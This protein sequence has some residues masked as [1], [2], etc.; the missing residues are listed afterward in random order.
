MWDKDYIG[1]DQGAII[2]MIENYRSGLVWNEFMQNE[3]IKKAMEDVGFV[4]TSFDTGTGAYPSIFGTHNGTIKPLLKITVS[5]LYTYP[6]AGTSGH[7][8]SIKLYENST[9]IANGTWDGYK[10]D[11]HNITL[12]N[13]TD[14]TQYVTLL[15]GH[16]YN[17]TIRTGSYP[18][19]LHATSKEV[20]GG[21]ITCTSF[22]DARGCP[23]KITAIA[24]KKYTH[25]QTNNQTTKDPKYENLTRSTTN[26]PN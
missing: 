5:K 2:L 14:G 15:R 19:I 13:V 17:Y 11:W 1:I 10:E 16:D 3:Y 12:H 26:N 6:C 4:L 18:Q 8:E 20:T 22:V 7:T 21:T 9:L 23:T 25:Q 24:A